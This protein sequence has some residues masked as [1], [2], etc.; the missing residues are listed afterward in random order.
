[1]RVRLERLRPGQLDARMAAGVRQAPAADLHGRLGP[2][3]DARAPRSCAA[4]APELLLRHPGADLDGGDPRRVAADRCRE[5]PARMRAFAGSWVLSTRDPAEPRL[6][7][8]AASA[9]LTPSP[10]SSASKC[11]RAVVCQRS[12]R[13]ANRAWAR[14]R[15][16]RA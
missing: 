2:L 1:V 10:A 12:C 7:S 9:A 8:Y 4:R 6:G 5:V 14:A 15:G 3:A 11:A 16:Q 13:S